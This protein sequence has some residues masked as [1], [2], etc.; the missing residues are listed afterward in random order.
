MFNWDLQKDILDEISSI[1][2]NS[3]QLVESKDFERGLIILLEKIDYYDK[4]YI[5]SIFKKLKS[6]ETL[7]EE[8]IDDFSF[9]I[10]DYKVA[11]LWQEILW[12]IRNSS[13]NLKFDNSWEIISFS[14]ILSKILK[15]NWI[16]R[17]Q[18]YLWSYAY[19]VW[20]IL[21][22]Y[23]WLKK[24]TINI[25]SQEKDIYL[26]ND[27]LKVD[28][29]NWEEMIISNIRLKINKEWDIIEFL[30]WDLIWEQLF[31]QLAAEREAKLQWKRLPTTYEFQAIIKKVWSEEFKRT[32]PGW[33]DPK[34]NLFWDTWEDSYFWTSLD[35]NENETWIVIMFFK[36]NN[37]EAIFKCSLNHNFSVRCIKDHS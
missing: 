23:K 9:F 34:N 32:L 30:E 18:S 14:K 4:N 13:I 27:N 22:D 3:Q 31:S 1:C 5:L 29:S 33:F 25:N 11:D 19:N 16:K 24:V 10:Y 7:N 26:D 2:I 17:I 37:S 8:E 15:G 20:V 12:K 6:W 35:Y 21:N 36:D 28:S